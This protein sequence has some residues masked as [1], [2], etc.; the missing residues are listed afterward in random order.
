MANWRVAESLKQLRKQ[1]NAAFPE[2]NKASDGSIGDIDH[3][4]RTSDH[5][6]NDDDVVCAIDITHDAHTGCTGEKLAA[7]LIK[8][9]DVRIKYIIFNR[10]IFKTYPSGGKLGWNWHPYT[11]K[12]AHAHH[13]H[14]SVAADPNLYDSK[15]MWNLDFDIA[16]IASESQGSARNS[17]SNSGSEHRADLSAA[18]SLEAS[19]TT[20]PVPQQT[21]EAGATGTQTIINPVAPQTA[22]AP[23]VSKP[24][25]EP[26]EATT[27]GFKSMITSVVGW[28]TGA[29]GTII[30]LLKDNQTL[31]IIAAAVL[32]IF[33]VLYFIRQLILDRDRLRIAADPT[34]YS[35][36]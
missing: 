31:L 15:V 1:I 26:I 18:H 6:P 36:K 34:K 16:V 13:I 7:A 8:S 29:G 17:E 9:R 2:R 3:S 23:I 10:R 28:L 11:G 25:D 32:V 12:N 21:N 4:A 14:V 24:S 27:G 5:N 30:A 22:T 20:E 35:A 19:D 33:G